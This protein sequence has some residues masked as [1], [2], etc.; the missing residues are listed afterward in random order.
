MIGDRPVFI[1][2]DGTLT[3]QGTQGGNPLSERIEKVRHMIA[4]GVAVVIWSGTG[5]V[6][7]RDFADR[8]GLAVLAAIGK[9]EYLVDDNPHIRPPGKMVVKSPEAFFA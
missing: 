9:P 8:H 5:T 1:D 6:Y 4:Q 2:I 7:A 3:D